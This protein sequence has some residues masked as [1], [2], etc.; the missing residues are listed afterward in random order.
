MISLFLMKDGRVA[1]V[2]TR[3]R[4]NASL[5]VVRMYEADASDFVEHII[6]LKDNSPEA[7]MAGGGRLDFLLCEDSG[8]YEYGLETGRGNLLINFF[9][10]GVN[11]VEV[12]DLYLK[13]DGDI[14][15]ILPRGSVW[16]RT[17]GEVAVFSARPD[18]AGGT[19]EAHRPGAEPSTI[20]I[21]DENVILV[22][23]KEKETVTLATL[24]VDWW[25]QPL[26]TAFNRSNSNY[27]IKTI[28]YM[29][30]DDW[31]DAFR[32]FTI[33][34]TNDAADLIV[35]SRGM[36]ILSYT[37]KGLFADLYAIMDT[38]PDFDQTDI[39]PNILTALEVDGK[40][41]NLFPFFLMKTVAGKTSYVGNTIG[42]TIDEFID[43]LKT[44]PESE[45]II[46][47]LTKEY[48]ILDMITY[49]FNDP[50]TGGL[51]FDREAFLKILE[52]AERFPETMPQLISDDDWIEF[53]LGVRDGNPLMSMETFIGSGSIRWQ[54]VNEMIYFGEAITYKGYPSPPHLSGT[55]FDP[56]ARFAIRETS[57]MKDGAW[58]FIKFM[59]ENYDDKMI[60][61]LFFPIK[62]SYFEA[63]LASTLVNPRYSDTNEEFEFSIELSGRNIAIGNNTPELNAKIMEIFTTTNVVRPIDRVIT[64]IIGEEVAFYLAG[65]K[66]PDQ[67]AD[68]I[69]NRVAI[70]LSELE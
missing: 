39:F 52:A 19:M 12:I 47:Y 32:R 26:I 42:W 64:R 46:G 4:N 9:D 41:Y 30:G 57:S 3:T 23:P 50:E 62:T 37:H 69:E 8:L 16:A 59:I 2:A 1:S 55:M 33:G 7:F 5:L 61:G 48:F 51:K 14:I 11:A 13:P 29:E 58:E 45:Y 70:Y 60:K 20:D 36:P 53:E 63:D 65:Q 10:H 68:I 24:E 18:H 43:F 27:M 54:R 22:P 56:P 28:S 67:I 44:K 66:S 6:T 35:M 49:Y 21:T 31:D 38:D 25:L 17:A 40:L 15:S 34:L